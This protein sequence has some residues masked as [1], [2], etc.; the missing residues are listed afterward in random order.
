MNFVYQLIPH[1][2]IKAIGW[3][4]FHSV[5]QGIVIA[6]I[7]GALLLL[8][9]KKSARLR[10]NI[11]VAAMFL[12]FFISLGTLLHV[13]ESPNVQSA[14]NLIVVSNN[15]IQSEPAGDGISSIIDKAKTNLPKIFETYFENNLPLVVTFWFVGFIIFSLRF[16]GGAL[17]VQ[18]LKTTGLHSLDNTW[19]NRLNFLSS[20][21]HLTLAVQISESTQINVPI[22]IGHLKPVIL[23]PLG[24]ISGLPQDQIEAI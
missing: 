21:L 13:Y 9:S 12:F 3:T 17:Y 14:D 15:T 4:I 16:I 5:W 20:K 24:M 7:L 10:Y 23:L 19:H 8:T 6:I 2:I 1:E 11:S 22:T 18:R